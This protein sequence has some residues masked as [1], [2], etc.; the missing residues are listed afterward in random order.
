M[1]KSSPSHLRKQDKHKTKCAL[2]IDEQPIFR[3]GLRHLVL[4]NTNYQHILEAIDY[5]SARQQDFSKY[6]I[7]VVIATLDPQSNN[8][9][10]SMDEIRDL[11]DATLF[12]VGPDNPTRQ[13]VLTLLDLGAG[14]IILRNS[15]ELDI[16]R[17]LEAMK[18]STIHL[19]SKL[20]KKAN[21]GTVNFIQ[22]DKRVTAST[23][24]DKLTK[25]QQQVL[26]E[27]AHG[28]CNRAIG[29]ELHI[30]ENT[31]KIHVAAILR[32]LGIKN[33]TQAALVATQQT[34]NRTLS[35]Q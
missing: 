34:S 2:I 6:N 8:M 24:I 1:S 19:S 21:D 11:G 28:K 22:T 5:S 17:A 12:I 7:G 29:Q 35:A 18:S 3:M 25:R 4:E 30:T 27:L 15:G 16:V 33:R 14:G 26:T 32:G 9:P 10:V 31:V 23:A 20:F 13:E